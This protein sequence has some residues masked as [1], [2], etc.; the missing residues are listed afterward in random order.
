M[1]FDRKTGLKVELG[2]GCVVQPW[3]LG[4]LLDM[5]WSRENLAFCEGM[6]VQEVQGLLPG[7]AG[8][9]TAEEHGW[10]QKEAKRQRIKLDLEDHMFLQHQRLLY[11]DQAWLK[12]DRGDS[13]RAGFERHFVGLGEKDFAEGDLADSCRTSST[14]L[15]D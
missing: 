6:P 14:R 1:S 8:E 12:K 4:R 10:L 13:H 3:N 9:W 5:G 7:I 2:P 15:R 11:K